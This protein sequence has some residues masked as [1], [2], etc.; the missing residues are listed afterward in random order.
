MDEV[1]EFC[2]QLRKAGLRKADLARELGLTP[3]CVSKWRDEPPEYALAF[4]RG[5]IRIKALESRLEPI[6]KA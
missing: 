3:N 6:D 4:L 1:S 5:Y 2:D